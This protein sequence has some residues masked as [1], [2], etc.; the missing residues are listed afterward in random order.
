MDSLHRLLTYP[1]PVPALVV[2]AKADK[3]AIVSGTRFEGKIV[4]FGYMAP[5]QGV[6]QQEV[7]RLVAP[8]A[9]GI[10]ALSPQLHS[11]LSTVGVLISMGL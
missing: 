10:A 3:E 5:I 4:Q 6:S 2:S 11:P 8:L 7:T 1:P 9:A